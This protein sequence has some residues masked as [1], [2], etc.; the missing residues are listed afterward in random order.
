MI[1]LH[2]KSLLIYIK[3]IAWTPRNKEKIVTSV[4]C[5]METGLHFYSITKNNFRLACGANM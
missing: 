1:V 4:F 2:F 5:N 3:H